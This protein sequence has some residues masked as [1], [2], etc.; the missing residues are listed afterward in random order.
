M[1]LNFRVFKWQL[2]K[3]MK[4]IENVEEHKSTLP[5]INRIFEFWIHIL[6]TN[7]MLKPNLV[8]LEGCPAPYKSVL[9]IMTLSDCN[10]FKPSDWAAVYLFILNSSILSTL[11]IVY[12]L[13]SIL[14]FCHLAS[15]SGD[16]TAT[17]RRYNYIQSNYSCHHTGRIIITML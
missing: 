1:F 4:R 9:I 16:I 14:S 15:A 10:F 17:V 3:C 11:F 12:T 5:N 2:N 7:V 6:C 13:S 8:T